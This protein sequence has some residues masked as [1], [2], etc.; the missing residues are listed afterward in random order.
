MSNQ[1]SLGR[2]T[3]GSLSSKGGGPD[4]RVGCPNPSGGNGNC[5]C[6][7]RGSAVL[8]VNSGLRASSGRTGLHGVDTC[9]L[10][11][12]GSSLSRMPSSA[13]VREAT[14]SSSADSSK[15]VSQ[16]SSSSSCM[17]GAR[18]LCGSWTVPHCTGRSP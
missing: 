5:S 8:A 15:E 1:T 18:Y 7:S 9:T 10:W 16:M 6:I 13:G 4:V 17:R 12:S 14:G 2:Q 3:R 11:G